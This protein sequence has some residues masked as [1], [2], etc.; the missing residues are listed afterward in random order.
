MNIGTFRNALFCICL[1]VTPAYADGFVGASVSGNNGIGPV[2]TASGNAIGA[3]SNMP[4]TTQSL[5]VITVTP[6]SA[7]VG[8]LWIYEWSNDTL[9]WTPTIC[10][11]PAGIAVPASSD[12]SLQARVCPILGS[13]FRVRITA[14]SSGTVSMALQLRSSSINPFNLV[15]APQPNIL[16]N[17]EMIFDQ[18][19]EG[20]TF[21]G[22]G[23]YGL[24]GWRTDFAITGAPVITHQQEGTTAVCNGV[25]FKA[26]QKITVGSGGSAGATNHGE[27][28][29]IVSGARI[30][31][32]GWGGL[33]SL[34]GY[35]T[36][37][38][39]SSV[40]NANVGVALA[41]NALTR[42]FVHMCNI[43]SAATWTPCTFPVPAE[44]TGAWVTTTG[45]ALRFYVVYECGSNW[46]EVVGLHDAWQATQAYCDSTQTQ[47]GETN[48]STL[49]V[50]GVKLE[51][52]STPTPYVHLTDTAELL[53]M[54]RYYQK[55]FPVGQA[56]SAGTKPA[57]GASINGATCI[58]QLV[59]NTPGGVWIPLNPPMDTTQALTLVG[60]A[61][62]SGTTTWYDKTSSTAQGAFTMNG[63]ANQAST[64]FAINMAA[65]TNAAGDVM[66]I[67]WSAD[68]GL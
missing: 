19:N 66:C 67:H 38:L 37:C 15:A 43:P 28:F 5:P 31:P 2:V 17:G 63:A 56:G 27:F 18:R 49:E 46:Q 9:S 6:S 11:D 45:R 14:I 8:A 48:A 3:L 35:V 59:L 41:N 24:D 64:G 52:G 55:S 61:P 23:V 7:G 60:Y 4:I 57:Q 39:K 26:A 25:V 34:P 65:G 54:R 62:V 29:Q 58:I 51:A 16:L 44:T 21:V 10:T 32:L 20:A 50:T 53:E 40:A 30:N 22:S 68:S 42:S 47:Y 13:F 1:F 33:S 12:A 36:V